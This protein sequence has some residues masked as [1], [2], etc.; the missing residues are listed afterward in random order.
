MASSFRNTRC[1]GGKDS[2]FYR[3]RGSRAGEKNRKNDLTIWAFHSV[4]K[5]FS[6]RL[7]LPAEKV[8]AGICLH[9]PFSWLLWPKLKGGNSLNYRML[10]GQRPHLRC[11]WFC[12]CVS[13]RNPHG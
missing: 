3:L 6:G 11:S 9:F 12:T 13:D 2:W 1:S 4:A 7:K 8:S 5:W 10:I